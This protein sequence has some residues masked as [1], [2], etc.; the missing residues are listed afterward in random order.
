MLTS[1]EIKIMW[2]YYLT[3]FL[4]G[5]STLTGA[6][7]Y[8]YFKQ[9]IGM[10]Y[11]MINFT[12]VAFLVVDVIF[13][14]PTG[15]FGDQ[16]SRKKQA[17]IGTLIMFIS[18]IGLYSSNTFT[19]I[20]ISYG[21]MGVGWAFFFG[22]RE[23]WIVDQLKRSGKSEFITSYY[24]N[25]QFF[26]M[27]GAIIGPLITSLVVSESNLRIIWLI[28]AAIT[29][30]TIL[31]ML[32]ENEVFSK[33][34]NFG[35]I[36]K[37]STREFFSNKKLLLIGVTCFISSFYLGSIAGQ[38]PLLIFLG[39]PL[40]I[41]GI[42]ESIAGIFKAISL[43]SVKFLGKNTRFYVV[44]ASIMQFLV[45]IPLVFISSGGW[46]IATVLL[47]IPALFAFI[48]PV[49]FN[50]QN[51]Q[52]PVKFRSSMISILGMCAS[53]GAII[54]Y[55]IGGCALD[56]IG[57]AGTIVIFSSGFLISGIIYSKLLPKSL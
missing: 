19:Q 51:T 35:K 43:A 29:L 17:I 40:F 2:K 3:S 50:F 13:E 28:D 36:F 53:I 47:L 10:T 46:L 30:L 52:M 49:I 21:I 6:Y 26:F 24:A 15:V 37:D 14:L 18:C 33:R 1:E 31:P 22:S 16:F 45:I 5:L 54:G 25:S 41:L 48:D 56:S 23:A 34:D 11:S 7:M 57:P 20:L 39:A 38:Q 27:V 9:N 12:I 55:L 32:L 42:K 8:L 44:L 4:I